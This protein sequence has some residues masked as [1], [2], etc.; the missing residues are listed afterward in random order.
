MVV[1]VTVVLFFLDTLRR[2][3]TVHLWHLALVACIAYGLYT[4]CPVALSVAPMTWGACGALANCRGSSS[5]ARNL[6]PLARTVARTA[7]ELFVVL[8]SQRHTD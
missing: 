8:V 4:L 5:N 2:L 6:T 1:C 7:A 3:F